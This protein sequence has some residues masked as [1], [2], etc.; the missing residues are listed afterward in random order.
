MIGACPDTRFDFLFQSRTHPPLACRSGSLPCRLSSRF[1]SIRPDVFVDAGLR[2]AINV[3][4]RARLSGPALLSWRWQSPSTLS[5]GLT[6]RARHRRRRAGGS[7]GHALGCTLPPF[8]RLYTKI[9]RSPLN[10]FV[11]IR[12]KSNWRTMPAKHPIHRH[13]Q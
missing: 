1:I 12:T 8:T 11:I 10:I 6:R 5:G 13:R 3:A 7:A 9:H 4:A 2:V